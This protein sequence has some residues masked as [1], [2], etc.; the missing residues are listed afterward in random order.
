MRHQHRSI[1]IHAVAFRSMHYVRM[2][3]QDSENHDITVMRNV[4]RVC[5][6]GDSDVLVCFFQ[7]QTQPQIVKQFYL[8]VE[9]VFCE[10][11]AR[12]KYI[13]ESVR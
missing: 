9:Y 1:S 10:L 2:W 11:T 13:R 3:R 4:H 5:V 8:V 12:S 7:L 6:N